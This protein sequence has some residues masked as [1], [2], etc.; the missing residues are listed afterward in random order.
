VVVTRYGGAAITLRGGVSGGTV[1]D[2][3]SAAHQAGARS[4][5]D[6]S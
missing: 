1:P 4:D 6:K 2:W 3:G 5:R